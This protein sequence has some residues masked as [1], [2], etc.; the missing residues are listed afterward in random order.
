MKSKFNICPVCGKPRG[1][2]PYEFAHGPCAE[3]RAKAGDTAD[4]VTPAGYQGD[5]SRITVAQAKKAK[6][7]AVRKSYLSGKLPD[8][9][10]S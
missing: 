1:R 10:Y 8:W 6:E 3:Q 9:M 7:K 5:F 4:K 2:G